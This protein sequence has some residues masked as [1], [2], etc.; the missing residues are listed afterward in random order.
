MDKDRKTLIKHTEQNSSYQDIDA[1]SSLEL[2]TN[3]NKEDQKVAEMDLNR[4]D[5]PRGIGSQLRLTGRQRGEP[6]P[7][8]K[9]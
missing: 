5:L 3:I 9:Q 4:A 1:M 8:T 2:V 6:V 7:S